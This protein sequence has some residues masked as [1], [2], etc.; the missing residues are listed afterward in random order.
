M[1]NEYKKIKEYSKGDIVNIESDKIK[2]SKSDD[3]IIDFVVEACS[4]K[5]IYLGKIYDELALKIY[6]KTGVNVRNYNLSLKASVIKKIMKDHGN[7]KL[8]G[9]RG[10]VAVVN[11]DFKYITNI[12]L[13][14]DNFFLQVLRKKENHLLRLKKI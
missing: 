13:E 4:N 1:N 3:D 2:I 12:I 11:E 10:R 14:S 5:K 7:E 6:L 8:E 9:L